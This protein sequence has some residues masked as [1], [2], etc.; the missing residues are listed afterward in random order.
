MF[1]FSNE[2]TLPRENQA[3]RFRKLALLFSLF[4][5]VLC[6][7]SPAM[8]THRKAI[9]MPT[10]APALVE[11]IATNTCSDSE[12]SWWLDLA[13]IL[14][15]T[16]FVYRR[17]NAAKRSFAREIENKETEIALER[18]SKKGLRESIEKLEQ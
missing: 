17:Y 14:L 12:P 11:T 8:A 16:T 13:L 6:D 7:F 15:S 18:H 9:P 3:Y 4:A 10:Q 1:T 2:L 5:A